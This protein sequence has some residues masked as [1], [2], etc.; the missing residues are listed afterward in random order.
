MQRKHLISKLTNPIIIEDSQGTARKEQINLSI[1]GK[2]RDIL[3][4]LNS[5]KLRL[6]SRK[7]EN[8]VT[9]MMMAS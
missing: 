2:P 8:K 7:K 3:R 1:R 9:L 4:I 5:I 6:L